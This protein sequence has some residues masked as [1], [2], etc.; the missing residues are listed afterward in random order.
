MYTCFLLNYFNHTAHLA[1]SHIAMSNLIEVLQQYRKVKEK[2]V[3][4]GKR[5]HPLTNCKRGVPIV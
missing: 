3:E 5:K 4:L 1:E 2:E